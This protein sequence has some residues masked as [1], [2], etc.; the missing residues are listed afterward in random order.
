MAPFVPP[1]NRTSLYVRTARKLKIT[2]QFV[3]EISIGG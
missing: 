3:P 1:L 2:E